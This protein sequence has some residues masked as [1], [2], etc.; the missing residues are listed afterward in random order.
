VLEDAV[1]I[2]FAVAVLIMFAVVVAVVFMGFLANFAL[3]NKIDCDL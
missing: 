2:L 3:P 1:A